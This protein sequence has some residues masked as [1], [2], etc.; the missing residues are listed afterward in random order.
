[1]RFEWSGTLLCFG[2]KKSIKELKE[3]LDECLQDNETISCEEADINDILPGDTIDALTVDFNVL[4]TKYIAEAFGDVIEKFNNITFIAAGIAENTDN[5]S[6]CDVYYAAKDGKVLDTALYEYS[7]AW[8]EDSEDEEEDY[9]EESWRETAANNALEFFGEGFTDFLEDSVTD[10]VNLF[11]EKIL[12]K[13]LL[14][15]CHKYNDFCTFLYTFRQEFPEAFW[16]DP[17]CTAFVP[18][19]FWEDEEICV[20]L[21]KIT[22][23]V[24][25]FMT[26]EMR[27][28]VTQGKTETSS[29]ASTEKAKRQT[30]A[31]IKI[32]GKKVLRTIRKEFQARF[33]YLG[34]SFQTP[35]QWNKA[36]EKGGAVT[37]LD[38]GKKL[39]EV[40]TVPPPKDEKEISIH[41]RTQ[42][43]NL[44]DNFLK[45]YG[46]YVQ[47]TYQKGDTVYYADKDMNAMGLTQLNKKMKEE[48]CGKKP[49]N[50]SKA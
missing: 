50:A 16:L 7:F 31:E 19:D 36:H 34:L 29:P 40:R 38:D 6:I 8:D 27:E 37:V 47:V 3:Y 46:L 12:C 4:Y 43:K 20:E 22:S 35:D 49:G 48:G 10:H 41:G 15:L 23:A 25:Q 44:A 11:Q 33:P 32:T 24:L 9:D 45:T 17:E 28:K 18:N 21:A 5:A 42:V 1:M 2:E 26:E 30:T 14:K 13:S 39:A